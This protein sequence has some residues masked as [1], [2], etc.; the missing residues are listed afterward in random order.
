LSGI[1][2]LRSRAISRSAAGFGFDDINAATE[3]RPVLD[4]DTA[5]RQVAF[6]GSGLTNF[7]ALAGSNVSCQSSQ[8]RNISRFDVRADIS[9][10]ANRQAVLF[11]LD[12]SFDLTVHVEVFVAGDRS[13][14]LQ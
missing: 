3:H 4:H 6:E 11:Q 1:I 8:D 5:G 7:D 2:R 13:L 9:V 14:H 10:G 12:G